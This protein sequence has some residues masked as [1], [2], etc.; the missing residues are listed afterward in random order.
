MGACR[1]RRH[2]F[3]L[4]WS[5]KA[6]TSMFIHCLLVFFV[7]VRAQFCVEL[8]FSINFPPSPWGH[9]P[10]LES[11]LMA[12]SGGRRVIYKKADGYALH[13]IE[14]ASCDVEVSQTQGPNINP[15]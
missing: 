3:G 11:R 1:P 9:E 13:F 12:S 14:S 5:K 8:L 6:H 2:D 10:P 4:D 15:K 7:G